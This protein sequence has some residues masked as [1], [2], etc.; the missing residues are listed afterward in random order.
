VISVLHLD[1]GS[2]PQSHC[3]P[4]TSRDFSLD[5]I[6]FTQF[7]CEITEGK[8]GQEIWSP[9]RYLFFMSSLIYRKDRQIRQGIVCSKDLKGVLG[10][11]M[12]RAWRCLG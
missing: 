11:E 1:W 5:A 12:S 8:A 10:P 2:L 4:P 3:H 9:I 6:L 7:V